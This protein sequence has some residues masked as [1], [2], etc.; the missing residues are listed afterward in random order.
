MAQS[1]ITKIWE[2]GAAAKEKELLGQL[3]IAKQDP[4]KTPETDLEG[5]QNQGGY[6]PEPEV[7]TR[8]PLT[9]RQQGNNVR[10]GD[11]AQR[12]NEAARG[13]E[14]LTPEQIWP[15]YPN[16]IKVEPGDAE[17]MK[18]N[19]GQKPLTPRQKATQDK[20]R[21]RA[22]S[23]QQGASTAKDILEK[24]GGSTLDIPTFLQNAAPKVQDALMIG[25]AVL[26]EIFKPNGA[27]Q[28]SELNPAQIKALEAIP[29]NLKEL[30]TS[31]RLK[32]MREVTSQVKGLA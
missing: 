22:G 31:D 3:L 9:P 20:L 10:Q 17:G 24:K 21:R 2:A 6:A 30:P 18:I 12:R 4:N 5:F 25:G 7:R 15:N 8:G 23:G 14:Q 1:E 27:L 26:W 11:S 19:P 28:L 32:I 29:S 16:M 13:G